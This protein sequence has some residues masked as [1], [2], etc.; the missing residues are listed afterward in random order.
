MQ[1]CHQLLRYTSTELTSVERVV[2]RETGTHS[3]KLT[4]TP[5]KAVS[6]PEKNPPPL[7]WF[8]RP[9]LGAKGTWSFPYF[10]KAA[11]PWSMSLSCWMSSNRIL[12]ASGNNFSMASLWRIGKKNHET[13]V[14]LN[15]LIIFRGPNKTNS[16]H[17]V[18]YKFSRRMD[19]KI[20][21]GPVGNSIKLETS[22]MSTDGG[23][24]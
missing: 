5:V 11:R 6:T 8:T 9:V 22:Y 4:A 18:V 10:W 14:W 16:Q 15:T 20:S 13:F 19:N 1:L 21:Y 24:A 2:R 23:T 17:L 3:D 12:M 7:C